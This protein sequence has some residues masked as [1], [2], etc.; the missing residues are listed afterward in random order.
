MASNHCTRAS[1]TFRTT[2][3]WRFIK[4]YDPYFALKSR[5]SHLP[6]P[7]SVRG[8]CSTCN[9]VS[10]LVCCCFQRLLMVGCKYFFCCEKKV[11]FEMDYQFII[12]KACKD[13]TP[14]NQSKEKTQ[15]SGY[16]L[17]GCHKHMADC[18]KYIPT[19]KHSKSLSPA[20]YFQLCGVD[21]SV[22]LLQSLQIWNKV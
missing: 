11:L 6:S 16:S 18:F 1:S 3:F 8:F 13:L 12:S 7:P 2:L 9:S 22:G 19:H 10:T 4:E 14:K 15:T 21:S 5:V 17:V 20:T